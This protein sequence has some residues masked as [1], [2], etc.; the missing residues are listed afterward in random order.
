[1]SEAVGAPGARD[2]P[3]RQ[4]AVRTWCRLGLPVP[5]RSTRPGLWVRCRHYRAAL[6]NAKMHP[7]CL[8]VFGL[9]FFF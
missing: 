4:R 8:V 1:M 6:G 9:L 5:T 3:G 2:T 7:P